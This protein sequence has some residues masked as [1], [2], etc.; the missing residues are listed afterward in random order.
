MNTADPNH[1]Q[2]VKAQDCISNLDFEETFGTLQDILQRQM[3]QPKNDCAPVALSHVTGLSY[4]AIQSRLDI[5]A[6]GLSLCNDLDECLANVNTLG[7]CKGT[8]DKVVRF[9][10][11]MHGFKVSDQSRCICEEKV[12][13]VLI[14]NTADGSHVAAVSEGRVFGFYDVTTNEFELLEMWAM[15]RDL[16]TPGMHDVEHDFDSPSTIHAELR[17]RVQE[18]IEDGEP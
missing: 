11:E 6:E 14:G 17:R 12:P 4:L 18:I 2:H 5:I 13:L 7:P 3:K 9:F 8:D 15:D 16:T 10:L 1:Q